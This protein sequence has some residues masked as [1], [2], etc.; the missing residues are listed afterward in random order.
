MEEIKEQKKLSYEELEGVAV[1]LQQRC[2]MLENKLRAINIAST[3]LNY[4]F[5]VIEFGNM[6]TDEFVDKCCTE[7]EELLTI[8]TSIVQDEE[9]TEK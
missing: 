7:V 9:V 8:D 6:F 3:R 5:K 4:L 1:Q 2:V